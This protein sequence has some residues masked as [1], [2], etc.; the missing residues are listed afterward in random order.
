MTHTPDIQR[1]AK[2]LSEGLAAA[3]SATCSAELSRMG[4]RNAHITGPVAWTP[5][6]WL[7]GRR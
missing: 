5:G 6:R 7:P 4:I 2:H 1:P 3:G